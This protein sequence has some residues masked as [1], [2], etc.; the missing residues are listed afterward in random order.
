MVGAD[1]VCASVAAASV[2]A[3]VDRDALVVKMAKEYPGYGLE[4]HK[5]YATAVHVK[6]METLGVS[7]E[8]RRSWKL[9]AKKP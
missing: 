7:K 4:S 8:H 1:R 2:L 6:A 9:P 5:G 3:K